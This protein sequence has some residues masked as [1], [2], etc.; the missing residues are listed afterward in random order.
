MFEKKARMEGFFGVMVT[1]I[2][3]THPDCGR[4]LDEHQKPDF[5]VAETLLCALPNAT[6]DLVFFI[7][8]FK[9]QTVAC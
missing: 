8:G 5:R 4:A 3:E 7:V 1:Y 2:G 9:G 6:F